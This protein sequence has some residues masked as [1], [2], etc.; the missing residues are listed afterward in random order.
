VSIDRRRVLQTLAAASGAAL[1]SPLLRA[2][3]RATQPPLPDYPFRIG[4]ASGFP[5]EHSVVLW[6]RLAPV[7]L[8]EDGLGG[9][10][11]QDVTVRYELAADEQF[12]KVLR[13]GEIIASSAWAHSTRVVVQRL[14]PAR[15]YFYRFIAGGHVSP[16]GRTRTL[17]ELR[18][19]VQAFSMAAVSCQHFE[20][21]YYA[22]FG[23]I[24]RAT[25]DVL[26]HLGDYIYE[27]AAS[28]GRVR[29][30]AGGLCTTLNEY[31]RRYAQYKEDPQLQ[32]AHAASP[33][34]TTWDDHDVSNDYAGL[35]DGRD[36]DPVAFV[37]RRAAAYRAY[38]ENM[39][40]PP[41]AAPD[42]NGNVALYTRRR[43]GQ[44]ANLHML[45][46]RQYRSAEACP[47]PG[48]SGG[49][50]VTPDC[51]EL[52]APERTMLGPE[53]EAWLD[54]GLARG[55]QG[56]NLIAQGTMVAQ[57]DEQPGTG[58]LYFTDNW[59][60][61]P[62]ARARLTNTLQR[63]RT[64]NPVI[65][66]GD[67]HAFVA[68]H[69]NAIA[70]QPDSPVVAPEFVTTSITSDSRPQSTLDGWVAENPNLV[71]TE[72]RY[73]GYLALRLLPQRLEVDMMALDNRDDAD[74]G[75]RVLRAFVVEAGGGKILGR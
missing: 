67:L 11:P 28:K 60:G 74:S 31:R 48:K 51:A 17:P 27:G 45:D 43:I 57:K 18:R 53:Q 54:A 62:A 38:F 70:G 61:Y 49:N 55:P 12:R 40:L 34:F 1:V 65:L 50:L 15:D 19:E 3:G 14:Q 64:R 52:S 16:I 73:R 72:G 30:H 71:M 37:A 29:E 32:A 8:A 46:Q 6:T 23:H 25:P 10:P 33:W 58:E 36:D 5:T 63:E 75:Q 39:P 13:H 24:A 9:M 22:A 20:Q 44:L 35:H 66:S 42:R 41:S 68:A 21:G 4:V 56:W 26:L 59:S 2:S 7:P 69:V 47:K